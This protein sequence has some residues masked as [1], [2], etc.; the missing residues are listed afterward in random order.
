MA[1]TTPVIRKFIETD[2]E[3]V[4]QLFREVY[5]ST[6]PFNYIYDPAELIRK[7]ASGEVS[8]VVATVDQRVKGYVAMTCTPSLGIPER[9]QSVVSPSCQGMGL[10]KQML[11]LL[12]SVARSRGIAGLYNE[13]VTGHLFSQKGSYSAGARECGLQLNYLPGNVE[14]GIGGSSSSRS[15]VVVYYANLESAP[16][17]AVHIPQSHHEIISQIYSRIGIALR[18]RPSSEPTPVNETLLNAGISAIKT[19]RLTIHR[20]GRDFPKSIDRSLGELIGR[21]ALMVLLDLP[22]GDGYLLQAVA[23][24]EAMGFIFSG[25]IP[26]YYRNDDCLRMQYLPE[27]SFVDWD[28]MVLASDF[29]ATLAEHV[30]RQ[31]EA[32]S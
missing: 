17:S 6:Y 28:R 3:E 21:D 15:A 9:G 18:P 32:H 31:L 5:G 24:A 12:H 16:E 23:E 10:F 2:A 20:Y 29:A 26:R 25:V 7:A 11:D 19:G 14:C 27:G 4:A 30:R 8:G 13:A 1:T 22:M